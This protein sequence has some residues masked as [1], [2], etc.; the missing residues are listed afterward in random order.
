MTI[1]VSRLT[2]GGVVRYSYAGAVGTLNGTSGAQVG[3]SV[4]F[5]LITIKDGSNSAVDLRSEDDGDNEAFEAIV[6]A[7]PQGVL[8]YFAANANTGVISVIVDGVNAPQA[9]ELRDNIR[10][11]GTAV[12]ANNVD[13]TG[14]T[15]SVGTSFT[16][17]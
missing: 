7:L 1:G 5:F 11:L 12:G 6:R 8:A 3:A 13:V 15:V 2:P 4:K 17:A 14:T 9:T 16:V 10:A